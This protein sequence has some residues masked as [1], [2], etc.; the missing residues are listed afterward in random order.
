MS[1]LSLQNLQGV[2]AAGNIITVASGSVVYSPGSIVQIQQTVKTDTFSAAPNG[3][4]TDITGMSVSI[5]PKKASSKIFILVTIE[6]GNHYCRR[7][8]FWVKTISHAWIIFNE[9][10]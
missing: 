9:R 2:V 8:Y 1:T 4:W 5:T 7:R 10:H 6:R 3:T